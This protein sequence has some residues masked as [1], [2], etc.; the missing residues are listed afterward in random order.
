LVVTGERREFEVVLETHAG[1]LGD[2][3][4]KSAMLFI[5]GRRARAFDW[6]G[7]PRGGHHRKGVLAFRTADPPR[8]RIA[9]RIARAGEAEPRVFRWRLR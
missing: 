7:D 2:D 1:D 9:L 6:R 3:L 4:M 8:E 5:D